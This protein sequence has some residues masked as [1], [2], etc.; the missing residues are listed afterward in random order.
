MKQ[1]LKKKILICPNYLHE[2]NVIFE[3]SKATYNTFDQRE[4]L[5]IIQN[6][7]NMSKD[8]I[9]NDFI[10]KNIVYASSDELNVL[11]SY[12]NKIKK[13]INLE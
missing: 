7:K 2:N 1:L 10:M 6:H 13:I 8:E 4:T 12:F 3:K 11:D 5:S 9:E